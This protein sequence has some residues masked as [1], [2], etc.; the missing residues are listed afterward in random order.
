[1]TVQYIVIGMSFPGEIK[2]T[3]LRKVRAEAVAR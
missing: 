3:V 1:M 2:V